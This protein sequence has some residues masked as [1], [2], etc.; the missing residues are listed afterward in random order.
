MGT[1]S[2]E[3]PADQADG[4]RGMSKPRPGDREPTTYFEIE[5]RKRSEPDE[6]EPTKHYPKLPKNNP[7]AADLCGDEPLIDRREDAD[8]F[9]PEGDNHDQS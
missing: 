7:W 9:I 8:H 4:V 1:H 5:Q 2:P 3:P 6:A